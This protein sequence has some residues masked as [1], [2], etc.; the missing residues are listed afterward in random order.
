MHAVYGYW[1]GTRVGILVV[2]GRAIP[3][4]YPATLLEED[5]V[6]GQRS[7]P[8]RALQGPGVGG[9][10]GPDV[11][12]AGTASDHPAGPV[13]LASQPSLSEPL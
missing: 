3:G 10:A 12:A 7:G 4:Y 2:P 13:G 5:P 8:R 1:V 11:P 9:P 6:A